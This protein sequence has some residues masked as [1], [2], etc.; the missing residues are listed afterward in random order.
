M[1]NIRTETVRVYCEKYADDIFV[2]AKI[3]G[4]WG[5]YSYS[6]LSEKDKKY[7]VELWSQK[8]GLPHRVV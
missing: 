4:K 6:S 5:S 3:H 2:R 7:W 1:G 8:E